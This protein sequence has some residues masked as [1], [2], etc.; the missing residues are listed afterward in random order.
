MLRHISLALAV[1]FTVSLIAQ[2]VAVSQASAQS[3]PCSYTS[4]DK[5]KGYRC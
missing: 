5:K 1:S 4:E 3:K 2:F